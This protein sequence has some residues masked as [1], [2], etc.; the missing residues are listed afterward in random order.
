MNGTYEKACAV[1][2]TKPFLL[3]VLGFQLGLDLRSFLHNLAALCLLQVLYLLQKE[4]NGSTDTMVTTLFYKWIFVWMQLWP[5]DT[6][7]ACMSWRQNLDCRVD[8]THCILFL[9][10]SLNVDC[11]TAWLLASNQLLIFF[12]SFF[13][14]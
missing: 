13:E 10:Y 4:L 8:A 12:F 3:V 9:T 2:L 1:F 6:K 7:V 14:V 11:N 5:S